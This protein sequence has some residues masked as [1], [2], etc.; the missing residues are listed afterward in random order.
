MKTTMLE[1]L[2][3][4]KDLLKERI[5]E[6]GLSSGK[7]YVIDSKVFIDK[8]GNLVVGIFENFL[9]GD[10]YLYITGDQKDTNRFPHLYFVRKGTDLS[11]CNYRQEPQWKNRSI[12]VP[13]EKLQ[14]IWTYDELRSKIYKINNNHKNTNPVQPEPSV[15]SSPEKSDKIREL[16]D[17]IFSLQK[18]ISAQQELLRMKN[19][20]Q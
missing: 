6:E 20:I 8:D 7:F 15:L 5:R 18:L 11:S 12:H 4:D 1:Q 2:P 14:I 3:V 16:E 10:V 13:V 9:R 17:Y 19:I